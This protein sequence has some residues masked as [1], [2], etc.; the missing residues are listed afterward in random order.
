M[1]VVGNFKRIN[2][3][4][5]TPQLEFACSRNRIFTKE[6]RISFV[7]PKVGDVIDSKS[8]HMWWFDHRSVC[9]TC[10]D[11]EESKSPW[12]KG[13]R[14][15]GQD[16]VSNTIYWWETLFWEAATK[17]HEFASPLA[18][19][20]K[21]GGR[22][23]R[24]LISITKNLQG[25]RGPRATGA[26][27]AAGC[28]RRGRLPRCGRLSP[29]V[30]HFSITIYNTSPS[31]PHCNLLANM[32]FDAIY[33]FPMMYCVSMSSFELWLVH[34]NSEIICVVGCKHICCLPR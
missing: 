17:S 15:H 33:C 11:R 12:I 3:L 14:S 8:C 1:K 30:R 9:W 19:I 23:W 27:P 34:G 5:R 16:E 25:R 4:W 31:H 28:H 24:G 2:F 10:G 22:G 26:T 18:A 6:S 13:V 32:M 7:I 29:L 21:K 20:Y